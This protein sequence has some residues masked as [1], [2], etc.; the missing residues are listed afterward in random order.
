MAAADAFSGKFN[1]RI[2]K[3]LHCQ[4]SEKAERERRVAL[5]I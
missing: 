5:S 3:A 4:L 1:V 2:P